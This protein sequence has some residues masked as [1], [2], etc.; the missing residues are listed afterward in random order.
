MILRVVRQQ[1]W[2]LLPAETLKY[3][4]SQLYYFGKIHNFLCFRR[5]CL[6]YAKGSN[7]LYLKKMLE[8]LRLKKML[9]LHSSEQLIIKP[10]HK[11]NFPIDTKQ[12]PNLDLRLRT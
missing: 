12:T 5:V 9:S 3:V 6:A 10:T 4:E 8:F 11:R 1:I 2:I 7:S